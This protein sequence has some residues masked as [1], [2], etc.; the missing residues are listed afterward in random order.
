MVRYL[1][2]TLF[3]RPQLQIADTHNKVTLKESK[4]EP[5]K[6][7]LTIIDSQSTNA[8]SKIEVP[9]LSNGTLQLGG[10]KDQLCLGHQLCYF[11]IL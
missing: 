6:L 1:D 4:L 9:V 11:L 5:N 10:A 8:E 2:L 3:I 7:T